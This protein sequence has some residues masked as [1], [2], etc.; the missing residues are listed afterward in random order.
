MGHRGADMPTGGDTKTSTLEHSQHT[1]LVVDDSPMSLRLLM[2]VLVMQGYRV[3]TAT[4]GMEALASVRDALPDL[5]LLDVMM[6]GMNGFEVAEHLR[7][8]PYTREVPIIFVSALSDEDKKVKALS[9]G[10]VDY[11]SKPIHINEIIARVETHLRLR[12]ISRSLQ[13]QLVEREQ[14]IAEL[15]AVNAQLKNEIQERQAAQEAREASL[16]LTRHALEKTE[17]LFRIARSLVTSED[18]P[19]MLQAVTDS[20]ATALH[21]DRSL[22]LLLDVEAEEVTAVIVGGPG[23]PGAD[24]SIQLFIENATYAQLMEG[25]TGWVVGHTQPVI[26]PGG[27]PDPRESA[28]ARERR[29]AARCG[30]MMIVPIYHQDRMMGTVGVMNRPD[31]P[32]FTTSDLSQLSAIAGQLG[33]ALA[34]ARLSAETAYLKEFNESIVQGVAEA[35]LLLDEQCRIVFANQAAMTMLGCDLDGLMGRPHLEF[36]PGI[37]CAM[38]GGDSVDMVRTLRQEIAVRHQDGTPVPVLASTR[39]LYREGV[40]AGFLIVLTDIAEIKAAEEQLRQYAADLEARNAELDAFAHTVAHDLRSPLTGIIGFADLLEA[41]LAGQA[42]AQVE[43]YIAYLVGNSVKMNN[44]INELLLLASV[45]EQDDVKTRPLDMARIAREARTRLDYLITEYG[46]VVKA[47][48]AWPE[49]WGYPQWV[50]EV[51]A[52]Y[53][54]NAVKYGG[55]PEEGIAPQIELGYD[56]PDERDGSIRF[57][58]RDNGPGLTKAQQSQLFTP[59]ERLHNVRAE[60]HGLGLSIVRRILEKLGGEAGI[61]STVGEGSTFYFTLP[62]A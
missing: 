30:A 1:I 59:F 5:V 48:A 62:R 2:Q 39:S 9:S 15:D 46:A 19:D 13:H 38:E 11:V 36:F 61:E 16:E 17:A 28:A 31:R 50:E 22:T 18:V 20:V 14:L 26:S 44:I 32:D 4:S 58:V 52:N 25:L 10:G 56:D 12:D 7:D 45:R 53:L 60:G 40:L 42:N 21:V 37:R 6:P 24:P 47:P 29:E 35:I 51:W 33:V 57:W 41:A 3:I 23:L 49:A 43:E 54:S 55:R 34:N 8:D 27:Y